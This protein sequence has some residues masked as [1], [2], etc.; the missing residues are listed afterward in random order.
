[1]PRAWLLL[2]GV[3]AQGA[4]ESD[5]AAAIDR[6]GRGG[7]ISQSRGVLHAF[8]PAD[9]HWLDRLDQAAGEFAARALAAA[10]GEGASR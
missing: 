4:R 3:G 6:H 7:L 2:P 9:P 10:R 8:A 1:M 5:C